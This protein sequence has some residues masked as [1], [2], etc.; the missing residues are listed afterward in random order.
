MEHLRKEGDAFKNP[1][2]DPATSTEWNLPVTRGSQ[3]SSV[4]SRLCP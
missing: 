3:E 2:K 1:R 4:Y